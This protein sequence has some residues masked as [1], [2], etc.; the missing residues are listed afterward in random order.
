[1]AAITVRKCTLS[2]LCKAKHSADGIEC[3]DLT[4]YTSISTLCRLF[5]NSIK[6]GADLHAALWK[7]Y[8]P[9]YRRQFIASSYK[10]SMQNP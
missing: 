4:L 6:D 10:S 5:D 3:Y 2:A 7:K 9:D 8:S 1:M